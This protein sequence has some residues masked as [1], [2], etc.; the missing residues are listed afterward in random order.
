MGYFTNNILVTLIVIVLLASC[1]GSP[2]VNSGPFPDSAALKSA[3]E[4]VYNILNGRTIQDRSWPRT[5]ETMPHYHLEKPIMQ[6][7]VVVGYMIR[8]FLSDT[9]ETYEDYY[10]NLEQLVHY[11]YYSAHNGKITGSASYWF[12]KARLIDSSTFFMEPFGVEFVL[13]KA[14]RSMNLAK[15]KRDSLFSSINHLKDTLN[16]LRNEFGQ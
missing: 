12:E 6:K 7:G 10:F 13:N 15:Y 4:I 3:Y 5:L 11:R 14:N 16:L 2:E 9:A 1:S 8:D